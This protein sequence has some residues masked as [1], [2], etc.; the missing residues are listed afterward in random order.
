MT[1][2]TAHFLSAF[3]TI[4]MAISIDGRL[5]ITKLGKLL[6]GATKEMAS[7]STERGVSFTLIQILKHLRP[8]KNQKADEE[9][10]QYHAST[11]RS[12]PLRW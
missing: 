9:N 1:G 12:T 10:G 5:G 4:R 11:E 3:T 2:A 7:S 8:S 6:T